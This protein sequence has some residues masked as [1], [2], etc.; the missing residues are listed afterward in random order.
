LMKKW[1]CQQWIWKDANKTLISVWSARMF[2][3]AH[4]IFRGMALSRSK[5]G[6]Q[7]RRLGITVCRNWGHPLTSWTAIGVGS[8][9][10]LSLRR[11]L[12]SG[13]GVGSMENQNWK[14]K[15]WLTSPGWTLMKSNAGALRAICSTIWCAIS[16]TS[17]STAKSSKNSWSPG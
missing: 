6:R 4:W 14:S 16:T 15:T 7:N 10:S 17:R 11:V 3:F 12:W 13:T 5:S 8:S 1:Q 9:T 2:N